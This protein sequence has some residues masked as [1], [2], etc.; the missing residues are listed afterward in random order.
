MGVYQHKGL[1]MA[2]ELSDTIDKEVS[3]FNE[4]TRMA[5][6]RILNDAKRERETV[7]LH[8]TIMHNVTRHSHYYVVGVV[9]GIAVV[10]SRD[11][12]HPYSVITL[13]GDGWYP[14]PNV[15]RTFDEALLH[16]LGVKHEGIN[17]QF[18]TYASKMLGIE[19][20]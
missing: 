9:N 4:K 12:E 6:Y 8:D 2:R 19:I 13:D 10:E 16:G 15:F 20:K 18:H 7:A 17:T 5:Q 1:I 14:K 3:E 11:T